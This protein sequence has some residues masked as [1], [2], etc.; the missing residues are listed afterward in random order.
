MDLRRFSAGL[1][2]FGLAAAGPAL[3]ANIPLTNAS[4]EQGALF[5][6][7]MPGWT[8][9][10]NESGEI[11]K[12]NRYGAPSQGTAYASVI[13]SGW[14]YQDS[15][16]TVLPN[17]T[18]V[19]S[20]DARVSATN[21][22]DYPPGDVVLEVRVGSTYENSTTLAST[23]VPL[24]MLTTSWAT[25][26]LTY[27]SPPS[28]GVIGQEL[29]VRILQEENTAGNEWALWDNVTFGYYSPRMKLLQ[30]PTADM[31]FV[32]ASGLSNLT[33]TLQ[34]IPYDGL[35]LTTNYGYQ[36]LA[37][38][39]ENGGLY[40]YNSSGGLSG[41]S[42][43]VSFAQGVTSNQQ[44]GRF[45]SNFMNLTVNSNFDWTDQQHPGNWADILKK[46]S[47]VAAIGA[48]AGA[49][50]IFFDPEG[51]PADQQWPWNFQTQVNGTV[52][53]TKTGLPYGPI[54]NT[55]SM[56]FLVYQRGVAFIKAINAQM[57]NA[58]ILVTFWTSYLQPPPAGMD[59]NS[60]TNT[61]GLLNAFML[62]ILEGASPGTVIVDG[63]EETYYRHT[64]VQDYEVDDTAI[65]TQALSPYWP[66]GQT[67]TYNAQAAPYIPESV[68]LPGGS[69][70]VNLQT[71]YDEKVLFGDAVYP[72]VI[73]P[74][75]L[76]ANLPG[77]YLNPGMT[78][79]A[80]ATRGSG[81]TWF[82]YDN[83]AANG[84]PASYTIQNGSVDW[85]TDANIVY[86]GT[87]P[88]MV[89]SQPLLTQAIH[90]GKALAIS[91]R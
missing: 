68:P 59:F 79:A 55:A 74:T 82:Y 13:R 8:Y 30:G 83:K 45:T 69:G 39:T 22:N 71:V 2:M 34:G 9:G 72:T 24:A 36:A 35:D 89:Y 56:Q 64:T 31:E 70:N 91:G 51:H 49:K 58:V 48:A 26:S 20:V 57:P 67:T 73:A 33:G 46:V 10:S 76:A 37:D 5:Q 61:Y 41:Q 29:W 27:T 44:W 65:V 78:A 11:Y 80:T 90:Q 38:M 40:S 15:G 42:G 53:N 47:A 14:I 60:A 54:T 4:F 77:M 81:Y 17:Q 50:G 12:E 21:P 43:T 25:F 16:A 6:Q 63:S 88:Y 86:T 85:V 7:P 66:P 18:Y 75:T 32:S 1:L 87:S 3:G 19:L 62:G 23:V 84:T 28:G 52:L